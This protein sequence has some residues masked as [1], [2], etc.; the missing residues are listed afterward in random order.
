MLKRFESYKTES[1]ISFHVLKVSSMN[2]T[3]KNPDIYSAYFVHVL[4]EIVYLMNSLNPCNHLKKWLHFTDENTEALKGWL[5]KVTQQEGDRGKTEPKLF[6]SKAC[7]FKYQ[8]VTPC[9]L[10]ST[11]SAHEV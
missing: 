5:P 2:I 8:R 9:A 1:Y 4:F 6:G 7:Q 11:I 3:K 10:C